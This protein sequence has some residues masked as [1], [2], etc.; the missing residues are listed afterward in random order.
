[1]EGRVWQGESLLGQWAQIRPYR[2]HSLTFLFPRLHA[3]P[4]CSYLSAQVVALGGADAELTRMWKPKVHSI[5]NFLVN[6][7]GVTQCS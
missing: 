5:P 7:G 3:C 2:F 4:F 6:G 1:M